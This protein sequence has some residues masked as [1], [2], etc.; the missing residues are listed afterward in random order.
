M[1]LVPWSPLDFLETEADIET[2]MASSPA[3]FEG[4]QQ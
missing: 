4:V 3:S 1:T 2:I